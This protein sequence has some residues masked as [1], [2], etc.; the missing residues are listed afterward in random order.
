MRKIAAAIMSVGAFLALASP[1]WADVTIVVSRPVDIV[2]IVDIGKLFG[3]L[4][5]VLLI[6]A[7]IAAFMYLLYGG[8][9]WIISGGDK[10]KV[11]AAQHRIQAALLGLII[12]FAVW[13]LF[14]VIGGYLGINIFA[15]T[16]PS[17]F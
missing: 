4:V 16:L 8:I 9:Q 12:V 1:V 10:A 5:G 14:T 7:A 11:E 2:R 13:A 17:P 15:P 3:S 6:V